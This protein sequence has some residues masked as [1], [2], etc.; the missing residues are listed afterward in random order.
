MIIGKWISKALGTIVEI[1]VA[2]Q[3][4]KGRGSAEI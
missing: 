4:A 3:L 1:D 2:D